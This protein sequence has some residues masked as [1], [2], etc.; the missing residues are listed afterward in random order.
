[1][2]LSV[3]RTSLVTHHQ[4]S[5]PGVVEGGNRPGLAI[6]VPPA[7]VGDHH[8]IAQERTLGMNFLLEFLQALGGIC[9]SLS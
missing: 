1:M 8:L 9:L 2:R 3:L 4:V 7:R 6:Q 5:T